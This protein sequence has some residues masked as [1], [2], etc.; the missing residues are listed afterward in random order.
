MDWV[1]VRNG[2]EV[3]ALRS[4]DYVIDKLNKWG[5]VQYLPQHGGSLISVCNDVENAKRVCEEHAAGRAPI[6]EMDFPSYCEA[7]R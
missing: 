7:Q 5:E 1:P 3:L 6:P 2:K 4:G